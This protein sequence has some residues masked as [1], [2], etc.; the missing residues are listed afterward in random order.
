MDD[1]RLQQATDGE[2][3]PVPVFASPVR[4]TGEEEGASPWTFTAG[5]VLLLGVILWYFA[6]GVTLPLLAGHRP[7]VRPTPTAVAPGSGD[8][9]GTPALHDREPDGGDDVTLPTP[10]P[11]ESPTVDESGFPPAAS[12]PPVTD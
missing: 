9:S 2:D 11:W 3:A 5:A 7:E 4:R 1:H 6:Y 10:V 12:P 8:A